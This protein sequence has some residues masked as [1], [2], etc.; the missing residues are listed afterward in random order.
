[1]VVLKIRADENE[2]AQID[3]KINGQLVSFK[4][5][6]IEKTPL[7]KDGYSITL[8]LEVGY[9]TLEILAR[10]VSADGYNT[11]IIEISETANGSKPQQRFYLSEYEVGTFT[12]YLPLSQVNLK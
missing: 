5:Q 1:V 3:L 10:S 11:G 12:I 8:T 6:K 7:K 4:G 2:G 9:N